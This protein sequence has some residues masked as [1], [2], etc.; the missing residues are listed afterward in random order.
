MGIKAHVIC[1]THWD[2]EWYFTRE[3]FRTKLI[4]LID[5]LL[6]LVETVPEYVSFMLDGQTILLE[7]YLEIKPYN[8]ERL[9]DAMRSGKIVCG[10]WYILPDELLISGESH[11]RNYI[12][13]SKVSEAA[14]VSKMKTAYL[15]DSFGHP[16]QMPQIVSGL[17]MDTMVFWRGVPKE[18]E[19]TEFYWESPCREKKAFCLHLLNGYGNSANLSADMSVTVPRVQSMIEQLGAH[20]TTDV[21]LLMNGSDHI[22]GQKNIAEIIIA[23]QRNGPVGTIELAWLPQYTKFGNPERDVSGGYGGE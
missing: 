3:Q 17:G 15:P 18:V 5:G 16:S 22:T 20:S 4:R 6:E 12:I 21:V 9:F 10:P 11:I 13:G 1:H 8:R 23:K 19:K 7:D 14:G 2:R